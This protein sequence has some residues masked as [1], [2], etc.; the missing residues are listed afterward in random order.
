MSAPSPFRPLNLGQLVA[1]LAATLAL[2]FMIS[3]VGKSLQAHRLQTLQERLAAEQGRL[4]R[5]RDELIKELERRKSDL[6]MDELLRDAGWMPPGGVRVIPVTVTPDPAATPAPR[7]SPTSRQ[8]PSHKFGS[9][10]NP[11]WRA[12]G[13][14]I[15]GFD[16][17]VSP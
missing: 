13:Q 15:W 10:G 14:L 9:F 17:K 6:W 7:P 4:T 16:E 5:E 11:Q 1:V 2:F 8:A 12:W 3:F